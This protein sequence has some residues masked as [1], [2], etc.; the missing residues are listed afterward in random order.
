MNSQELPL[1]AICI[2]VTA[3]APAS[4]PASVVEPEP[5]LLAGGG[6]NAPALAQGCCYV[7]RVSPNFASKRNDVKL[8]ELK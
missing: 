5:D 8:F 3:K 4:L 6:L 2:Q 7:T 1:E